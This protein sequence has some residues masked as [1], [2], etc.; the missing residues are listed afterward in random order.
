M[1]PEPVRDAAGVARLREFDPEVETRFVGDAIRLLCRELG[2]DV[3]V[4]GFAAA[5]WTLACYLVDGRG[6]RW[7]SCHENDAVV[8]ARSFSA[9]CWRKS[10]ALPRLI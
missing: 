4:I 2:P 8:R 6:Q 7:L 10:R 5:P 9:N 3:P 1:L